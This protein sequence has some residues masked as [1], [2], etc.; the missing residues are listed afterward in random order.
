MARSMSAKIAKIVLS[1]EGWVYS[2]GTHS[3]PVVSQCTVVSQGKLQSYPVLCAY[4]SVT[5]I[6]TTDSP[7]FVFCFFFCP[8]KPQEAAGSCVPDQMMSPSGQAPETTGPVSFVLVIKILI[9]FKIS[10][11]SEKRICLDHNDLY[12][13]VQ[14]VVIICPLN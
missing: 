1:F 14:V 9:L 10:F 7:E 12:D 11:S 2:F 3:G 4:L 6:V 13:E 8:A 5:L